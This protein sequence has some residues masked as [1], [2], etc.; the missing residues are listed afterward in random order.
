MTKHEALFGQQQPVKR[1]A[2]RDT[3]EHLTAFRVSDSVWRQRGS[4]V[5]RFSGTALLLLVAAPVKVGTAI[6]SLLGPSRHIFLVQS[7]LR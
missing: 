5:F 2:A 4:G 1:E 3:A 6:R 7:S